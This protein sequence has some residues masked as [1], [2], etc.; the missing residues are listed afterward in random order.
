MG[1]SNPRPLHANT[2]RREKDK[3][4]DRVDQRNASG[5]EADQCDRARFEDGTAT[6][7]GARLR[8]TF[9]PVTLTVVEQEIAKSVI[10]RHVATGR[11]RSLQVSFW[12]MPSASAISLSALHVGANECTGTNQRSSSGREASIPQLPCVNHVRPYL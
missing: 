5:P 9:G 7:A 4:N 10:R 11:D 2:R 3:A 6:P 12:T 8:C 1:D